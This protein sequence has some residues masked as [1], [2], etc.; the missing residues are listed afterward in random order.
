MHLQYNLNFYFET[1]RA[2]QNKTP[3]NSKYKE[4]PMC[5]YNIKIYI[6]TMTTIQKNPH[7]H[8]F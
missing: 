6:A 7:N 4:E 2:I 5:S 8:V 3:T 1:M